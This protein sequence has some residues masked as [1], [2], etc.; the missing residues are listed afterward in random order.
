M[1]PKSYVLSGAFHYERTIVPDQGPAYAAA[2]GWPTLPLD[3][4]REA[5]PG[6]CVIDQRITEGEGARLQTWLRTRASPS[7]VLLKVV[8]PYPEYT[9]DHPYYR[10]L[11]AVVNLPGVHFLTVY[12]PRERTEELRQQC[13]TSRMLWLPY[14]YVASAER[15]VPMAGRRRRVLLT[16]AMEPGVYPTRAA[17]ARRQRFDPVVRLGVDRL[18]HP[19]YPDIGHTLKHQAVGPAFVDRLT[20][21]RGMVLDPARCGLEFLKYRECAYAGCVPVGE[22]PDSLREAVRD[23]VAPLRP[24][25]LWRDVRRL[26]S[27]S[28]TEAADRAAGYRAVLRRI[29]HPAVLEAT[30]DQEL[31]PLLA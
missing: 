24:S 31:A 5:P 7:P 22:L 26:L 25:H 30:L 1:I 11:F 6:V 10:L 28:V 8:D 17:L 13:T 18:P 4:L 19:G 15:E 21:Y 9:R 14:A 27:M 23:Y 29:R 12:E 20:Q 3:A 16:G 2:M